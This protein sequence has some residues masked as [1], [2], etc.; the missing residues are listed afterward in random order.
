[1]LQLQSG[2]ALLTLNFKP[3]KLDISIAGVPAASFNA[4][5][6]FQYEYLREKKVTPGHG[7]CHRS[8]FMD[9][10]LSAYVNYVNPTWSSEGA[11]EATE[12]CILW[13]TIQPDHQKA[14]SNCSSYGLISGDAVK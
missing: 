5:Q 8:D 11:N 4:R 7:L 1:M 14:L 3:L 2:T 12:P 6:M 13:H 9:A 10:F